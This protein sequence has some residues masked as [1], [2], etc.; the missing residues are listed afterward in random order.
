[1]ADVVTFDGTN[2]II[3]EISASGDNT[4]DVVEIYSE[5]KDW[6]RAGNANFEQAFTPV[7]GDEVTATLN[8]GTTFFLENGWRIRPSEEDHKLTLLGN[9]YTREAGESVAVATIGAYT[10]VV[11]VQTS[12]QV[13]ALAIEDVI[14]I[15]SNKQI[16]NS[17]TGKMEIFSDDDASII[18]EA[19]IY[20][21]DG[22]TPWDGTGPIIRRDRFAAP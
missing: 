20:E 14:R 10:V 16:V 13:Q 5:W 21:D 15:I 19:D 8:L 3:T 9:L 7:G 2:K 1:M 11:E 22:V 6:V 17:A 18:L 4:L 12:L